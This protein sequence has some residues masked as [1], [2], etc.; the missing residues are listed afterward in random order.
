LGM[1]LEWEGKGVDEV[2]KVEGQIVIRID[3]EYFRPSEVD[4]LLGDST[5]AREKLGWKPQYD[6]DDILNDM[7]LHEIKKYE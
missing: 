5:K 2:G 1:E 7:V 3:P 4:A 6:I